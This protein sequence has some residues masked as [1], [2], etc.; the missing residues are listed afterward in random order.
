MNNFEFYNPTQIVFGKGQIEKLKDLIPTDKKILMIFGGGSIK[1]NGV[2]DQVKKSLMDHTLF[3]F[4]GIESN[5][6][7]ETAIKAIELARAEKIDYLLAVGGGSVID[8]T[9]FISAAINFDGDAWDI[10][11]KNATF[12]NPLPFGTVLTLPATGSEMNCFSVMSKG[13]DKLGFGNPSLFPKFSILD[14]QVTYTLSEKQLGNGLVDAFVHTT[15]QYL[16]KDVNTPL[17]DRIAEGIL[18]TL[19][20]EADKVIHIKEDYESRANFMWSATMALNGLIG[21]GVVHDWATHMIGHELTALHGI[22]HGRSLAVVLPSLL[23]ELKEQKKVKLLQ[24][25]QRVWGIEGG[26]PDERIEKAIVCMEDF[27]NKV[28]VPTKLKVYKITEDDLP[29][30]V[31]ALRS[32]IPANLGEAQNIDQDMVLRILKRAL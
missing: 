10:P 17:Q 5:P 6:K 16:T 12:E 7:Y 26:T 27:F 13:S 4:G 30:I 8:A 25:A 19:V 15:E 2:Y 31:S 32:H 23:R 28:G 20:E 18:Q 14:P 9:K 22:D 3:E 29:T 21:S 1:N 24:F 11:S